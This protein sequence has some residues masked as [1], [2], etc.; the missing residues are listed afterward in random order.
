M[1]AL[2]LRRQTNPKVINST[3]TQFTI[4][5][6]SLSPAWVMATGAGVEGI[7]A[8][9]LSLAEGAAAKSASTSTA[10]APANCRA[11]DYLGSLFGPYECLDCS[12][13]HRLDS[14]TR[15]HSRIDAK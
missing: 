3:P 14:L 4:Q 6:R 12:G 15:S 7:E 11:V 5:A 1:V 8:T 13:R 9:T 10:R 2:E